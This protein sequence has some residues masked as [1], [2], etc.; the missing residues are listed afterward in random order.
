MSIKNDD[1]Q[2][3]EASGLLK[4]LL[5]GEMTNLDISLTEFAKHLDIPRSTIYSYLWPM[6]NHLPTPKTLEK[7]RL[8]IRSITPE[9]ARIIET[10]YS[11]KL[12]LKL[13]DVKG[14]GKK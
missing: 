1:K 10:A 7:M 13:A 5:E 14:R 12:L 6:N 9:R 3:A 4:Q 2:L 11:R 8:K